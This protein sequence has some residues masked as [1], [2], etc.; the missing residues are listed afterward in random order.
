[1][2]LDNLTIDNST[3]ELK[4]N[5]HAIGY[6][7]RFFSNINQINNS[8]VLI[9]NETNGYEIAN[10][11]GGNFEDLWTRQYPDRYK[12]TYFGRTYVLGGSLQASTQNM[13]YG[14][15]NN[16]GIMFSNLNPIIDSPNKVTDFKNNYAAPINNDNTAL[17]RFDLHKNINTEVNKDENIF[18]YYDPNNKD[19]RYDY[20]FQV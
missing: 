19:S 8:I 14:E 4:E 13:R 5:A 9:E 17:T 7:A 11:C 10:G 20:Q 16:K 2:G 12:L 18:T 1:M 6:A 3:I 15:G